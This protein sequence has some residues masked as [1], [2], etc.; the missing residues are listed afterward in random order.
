M[1]KTVMIRDNQT[2]IATNE[3]EERYLLSIGYRKQSDSN[4]NKILHEATGKRGRKPK[5]G[6]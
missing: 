1:S 4:S 2:V 6:N 5:N 3:F